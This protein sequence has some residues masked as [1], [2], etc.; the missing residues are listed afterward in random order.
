MGNWRV[1]N[2]SVMAI[3]GDVT[4]DDRNDCGGVSSGTGEQATCAATAEGE[5]AVWCSS[6]ISGRVGGGDDGGREAVGL[7]VC[8]GDDCSEG[9]E[10]THRARSSVCSEEME[11]CCRDDVTPGVEPSDARRRDLRGRVH[12]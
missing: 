12:Y 1:P 8:C 3:T 11:I 7:A 4:G 2:S 10:E 9:G 6:L 5:A